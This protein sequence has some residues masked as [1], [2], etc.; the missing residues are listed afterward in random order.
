MAEIPPAP[1]A[2]KALRQ[3]WGLSVREFDQALGYATDGR[4]TM[5]IEAGTRNGRAFEMTGPAVQAMKRLL[6]IK[7]VYDMISNQ[8]GPHVDILRG[9]LPER[10]R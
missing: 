4:M 8:D 2:V 9:A 7:T 6:T 10:M 3:S 5:A 1:A